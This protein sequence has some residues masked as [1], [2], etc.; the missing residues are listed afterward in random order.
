VLLPEGRLQEAVETGVPFDGSALEGRSRHIEVDMLLKPDPGTFVEL[1]GQVRAACTV[2]TRD[3]QPWLVDPRAALAD[4]ISR[5]SELAEH[6]EVAAELEF[7]FLDGVGAPLDNGGY[8]GD[9][10]GTGTALALAAADLLSGF[11]VN[12]VAAH[13]EAG[14]GQ[15]E[16]DIGAMAPVA[17]ADALVLAKAVL[18]QVAEERGVRVT[19]MARP[20][21]G[22]PGS[23]LHLHQHVAG[24]LFD[25]RWQLD[26][27]GRAFVGGQL[28]HARALTALA[29]PN[30]NSYQR[31][32]DG[33]EAPGA[34]VWG[35][36]SRN[37]VIRVGSSLE[38]RPSVEFRLADPGANPYLLLG[39][40]LVAAADGLA[41]D[42]D[43]GPA[44]DEDIGGY[45]PSTVAKI[46]TQLLPRVLDQALD[47]LLDDDVLVDAFD[48]QLLGRMVDGRRAEAQAYRAQVTAWELDRY[49]NDA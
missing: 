23:G 2:I 38:Q 40:L 4:V 21:A 31:L 30:V 27:A 28:F 45:D 20:L 35:H 9:L 26:E 19:F 11:G 33:P 15:Y 48:S 25:D 41:Q 42:L 32:H 34:V 13:L 14:P 36:Q 46:P 22:Q 16:L 18:R 43:P 47:A 37:A 44:F 49:L 8:F 29:A 3:G 1:G 24:R 10:S 17:M 5:T 7:Y 12:V 6:Y 39:G